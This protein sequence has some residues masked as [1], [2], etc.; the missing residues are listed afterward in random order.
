M[1]NKPGTLGLLAILGGLILSGCGPIASPPTEA[2]TTPLSLTLT[3]VAKYELTVAAATSTPSAGIEYCTDWK[4]GR[5]MSYPEAVEI[6]QESECAEEGQVKETHVCNEFT[7]AWWID[8]D[9]DE[10]GCN[11]ACVISVVDK[12]AEIN[13]RCTGVIPTDTEEVSPMKQATETPTASVREDERPRLFGQARVDS[14]EVRILESFPVQIHLVAQG[15]LPDGCTEIDQII[16]EREDKTF[17]VTIRTTRLADAIC[18][19]ALV[20]FEEVI[21]L[22]VVGL[23]A[24]KYT[25]VVNGVPGSFELSTDNVLFETPVAGSTST[26]ER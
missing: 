18:T 15:N 1:R 23:K 25:V 22:D 10:P 11:P 5:R 9:M 14:L 26:A 2:P 4:T 13:W 3:E 19:Q 8:L 16:K 21:L 6:A 17:V 7:G 24:G 12:T 20:P